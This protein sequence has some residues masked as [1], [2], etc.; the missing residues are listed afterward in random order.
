MRERKRTPRTQRDQQHNQDLPAGAALS[1]AGGGVAGATTLPR[2]GTRQ[3]PSAEERRPADGH[4]TAL[5]SEEGTATRR[6][7]GILSS[8]GWTPRLTVESGLYVLFIFL[9]AIT[10]FWDLGSR[11][12]HHD[13]SLHAYYSWV[14]ETG[15]GY[16]HHPLMHGPF[17]F[18]IEALIFFLFGDSDATSRYAPAIFGVIL[19][20]LP[21]FL[22][23]TRFLGRWGALSASFFLLISPSLFY[24][25]RY[26]RHDIFTIVGTLALFT[27]I[28]R[29]IEMPERRWL[30]GGFAT[31]ALLLTNHEVIFAILFAYFIFL[32]CALIWNRAN[33]WRT[34]RPEAAKTVIGVHVAGF[35]G[36]AVVYLIMPQKYHTRFLDIPWQNP[37]R[38]QEIDYYVHNVF[39]NPLIIGL[40]LVFVG[41]L[42]ALR[43]A[44]QSAAEPEV[45]QEEGIVAATLEGAEPGSVDD[46][47]RRAWADRYGLLVAIIVAAIL[48]TALFTSLY[49]NLHGLATST[50]ATNG[51]LLYWLGQHD[52]R[53][54]DQPWFYFL[55][56]FPQYEFVAATLGLLAIVAT[57]WRSLGAL[58]GRWDGGRNLFFR[59]FLVT[60][61]VIVFAGLSLAGEKM[62]WLVTHIALPGILLAAVFVGGMIDRAI[63]VARA[64]HAEGQTA[65]LFG[66]ADWAIAGSL[67]ALAFGWFF[68]AGR[69]TEG[70]FVKNGLNQWERSLTKYDVDHWWWLAI[71][72]TLA[73]L[74]C[75]AGFIWRGPRR[76]GQAVLVSLVIL[77]SLLQVH[78]EWRLTYLEGDVPKDMLVYTQTSP[79]VTMMMNDI[80]RLSAE[81]TGGNGLAIWYDSGVSWPMQWYLRDYPNKRFFGTTLTTPPGDVPIVLVANDN[82]AQVEAQ[83]KDYTPQ[84]Y[85]LR[86]W[87]PEDQTYRAFAIAPEI[88]PGR[89]AWKDPAAA[90]GPIQV[91][92]SV[93]DAVGTLFTPEGEQKAY[94]LVMYRD[95]PASIGQYRFTMYVRNDLLPYFNGTRY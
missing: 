76:A 18:H 90:H 10:R 62:P 13:E 42:V 81:L 8:A 7:L 39:E 33:Y 21:Y 29:Y 83:L 85:V 71:A 49:T 15:G 19:V 75:A 84:E 87:Y 11:A 92:G 93:A 59:L 30:I 89:S 48:F 79:D 72:P 4:H 54:G 22:R 61:F 36:F 73:I 68:I 28:V 31:T 45:M 24:M 57:L 32:Y 37:T 6:D 23:G 74:V 26:I 1:A 66:A 17:L 12:L 41:F 34:T 25:S 80:D 69:L 51:T 27:C 78:A 65:R 50:Y 20:G 9:A 35:V 47:V 64:K 94:R 16:R 95:L 56:L 88:E 46:A 2:P 86:W 53:R 60:W 58:T 38:Q 43:F 67:I 63:E 52:V 77:L 82:K 3:R 14:Y 91:L 5:L 70:Q 55:L 40:A 44:L